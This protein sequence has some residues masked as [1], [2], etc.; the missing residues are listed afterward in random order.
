MTNNSSYYI[1]VAELKGDRG[2]FNPDISDKIDCLANINTITPKYILDK[3]RCE[4]Y[5]MEFVYLFALNVSYT[6][7]EKKKL[8]AIYEKNIFKADISD[9]IA[10]ALVKLLDNEDKWRLDAEM[11]EQEPNRKKKRGRSSLKDIE[12]AILATS[13][14][15]KSESASKARKLQKFTTFGGKVEGGVAGWNPEG[16]RLYF[17]LKACLEA[18]GVHHWEDSWNAYWSGHPDNSSSKNDNPSSLGQAANL[19]EDTHIAECDDET[20]VI[21][22]Q[23]I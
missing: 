1:F 18:I 9:D 4:M 16:R 11:D 7:S 5:F 3:W 14:A 8:L 6:D 13:S 17:V 22:F 10:W 21:T 12:K 19:M 20:E 23:A 2:L 15:S